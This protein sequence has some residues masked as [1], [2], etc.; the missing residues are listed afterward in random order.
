MIVGEAPGKI[1]TQEGIAFVGPAG[2]LFV[3]IMKSIGVD[4]DRDV[5]LS[6]ICR[7]RPVADPGED[8]ENYTP[9]AEQ[10]KACMPYLMKEIE[11][12]DPKIL[13][14]AGRT[15][16]IS[17]FALPSNIKMKDIAG[18]QI[19]H[20]GTGIFGKRKCFVLYHPAWI[21]HQKKQ[22]TEAVQ[23]AK[24]LMWQHVQELKKVIEES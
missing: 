18:K 10:K 6:N 9:L 8:K 22:G 21:L 12:V 23:K 24:K 13:I 5:Y 16:A 7:C 3:Q 17:L 11:L 20:P 15:A 4:M 2:Q 14:A 1:E 19:T